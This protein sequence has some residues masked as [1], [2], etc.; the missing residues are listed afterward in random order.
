MSTSNPYF[1]LARRFS[2]AAQFDEK[3]Y[4]QIVCYADFLD[5][6]LFDTNVWER[7]AAERMQSLGRGDIRRAVTLA[8]ERENAR[9]REVV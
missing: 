7:R 5:K 1:S 6:E 2:P 8:W 9:R 4:Q 3:L